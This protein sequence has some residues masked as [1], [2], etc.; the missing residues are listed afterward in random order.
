[1]LAEP[2]GDDNDEIAWVNAAAAATIDAVNVSEI[3]EPPA[4]VA[5]TTRLSVDGVDG[6]VPLNV[7]VEALNESQDGN[8]APPDWDALR[9]S[10]SALG[11]EKVF[12]AK[13]KLKALPS[14]SV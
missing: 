6:A 5:L 4:S 7:R 11:S 9:V 13:L 3:D 1:M 14:V 10:A 12:E 2:T 8:E